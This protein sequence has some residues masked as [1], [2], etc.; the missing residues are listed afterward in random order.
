MEA[1]PAFSVQ[2]SSA[3]Q[4]NSMAMSG[5]LSSSL[6][7]HPTSL[8]ETFPKLPD[9]QQAF[10]EKEPMTRPMTNSSHL[11][12]SGVVGHLFSSSPG[13]STDLHHSS[14]SPHEKH[15]RNAHFISQ[16]SSNMAS[17]PPSYS[18]SSGP[19]P[20][21]ASSCYSKE[22][23]ASW[24]TDSL[25]SFLDFPVNTSIDNSHVESGAGNIM[26]SE[27]YCKKNDWQDWA[28]QLI[29]DDDPLTSNWSDILVDTSINDLEPKVNFLITQSNISLLSI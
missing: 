26:A 13:Y 7:V 12:S 17:L 4:F 2:R 6:P 15:S 23:N 25:S 24:G 14:L 3:N 18:S 21:T 27:D 10:V 20:S 19:L 9:F 11:N 22:S 5:A 1:R 16:S 8:G 29:S 28:D